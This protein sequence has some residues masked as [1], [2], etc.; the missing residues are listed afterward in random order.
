MSG[1]FPSAFVLLISLGVLGMI[2]RDRIQTDL[3]TAAILFAATLVA[4]SLSACKSDE[5]KDTE[6][7]AVILVTQNLQ[8]TTSTPSSTTTNA[9]CATTGPCKLFATSAN[10]TV[11]AGIAGLDANCAADVNKPS[12]GGTYKALVSDG[13]NRRACTTANCGT[14]TGESIDWV[15]KPNK[16][17]VRSNGTTVIGTTTAN[18]VFSFPL[19]NGFQ[20]TINGT[21]GIWTGLNTNW[22]SSASDCTDWSTTIATNASFGVHDDTSNAALS[23]GT[24]GCSNAAKVVCVEQ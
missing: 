8:T 4:L 19:T 21:N 9:T 11:N 13:T 1:K 7:I 10:A 23:V 5:N 2:L 6:T 16:Q 17:Y 3:K 15:L 24:A 20:A 18:G 12:G 14:G 22:T